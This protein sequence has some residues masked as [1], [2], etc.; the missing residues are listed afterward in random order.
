MV[1]ALVLIMDKLIFV[2][3]TTETAVD[4]VSLLGSATE[5]AAVVSLVF[6]FLTSESGL[7][8]FPLK[9]K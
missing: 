6:D 4:G 1:L 8:S 7:F 5:S 2:E 3:G 9:Q